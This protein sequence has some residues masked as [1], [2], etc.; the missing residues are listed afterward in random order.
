MKD[1]EVLNKV[2]DCSK[3]Y[4]KYLNNH[5]YMFL[6]FNKENKKITY[7]ET[8]FLPRNF[9]HLTGLIKK[10]DISSSIHFYNLCIKNDLTL[11]SI[12]IPKGVLLS[13]N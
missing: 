7:L 10:N 6:Y 1:Y 13:K 12:I 8:I 5:N 4:N 11:N 2:L 3:L 9:F